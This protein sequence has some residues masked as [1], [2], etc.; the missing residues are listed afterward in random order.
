MTAIGVAV[1]ARGGSLYVVEDF[2]ES[3]QALSRSQV[4]Q[5][6]K[7]LLRARN[8]D[9]SAPSAPAEQACAMGRGVRMCAQSFD[10]RRRV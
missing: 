8:V 5:R 10:S 1:I 6:V 2:D 9:A 4:E 7:E 3:S